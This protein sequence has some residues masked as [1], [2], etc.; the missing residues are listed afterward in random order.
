MDGV[1]ADKE[2]TDDLLIERARRGDRESQAKLLRLMQDRW[3]RFA[4]TQLG[5]EDKS[6]DAVQETA[7]RVLQKLPTFDRRST[8][9]TWSIGICLNVCRETRRRR[10]GRGLEDI[11]EPAAAHDE[12]PEVERAE[13]LGRMKSVLA[14]LPERQRE[15][16]V[17]RFFEGRSVEETASLMQCAAGTVK[18][19]VHQALRAMRQRLGLNAE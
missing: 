19:T 4:Y 6:R 14:D 16:L 2:L 11:S 15:A 3:F 7:V 17:L 10:V 8:F 9:S 12:N 13:S 18:A 1:Q 5:D